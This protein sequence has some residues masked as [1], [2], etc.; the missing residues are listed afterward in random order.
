[1]SEEVSANEV[2]AVQAEN[3][4][5]NLNTPTR[6]E[7]ALTA[8]APDN[9]DDPTTTTVTETSPNDPP[10]VTDTLSACNVVHLDIP[11]T[12]VEA[13]SESETSY[14]QE[15][16]RLRSLLVAKEAENVNLEQKLADQEQQSRAQIEQ[17]HQNFT[18]KLE[19][20]LRK[21][22]ESQKDKTSSMV[23]KYA[24]AEKRC[25]DL[26]QKINLLQSKLAAAANEKQRLEERMSKSK[27]ETDKLNADYDQRV[28]DIMQ[29]K[30][31]NDKL[32]EQLV[33]NE[34]KE[35]AG[36]IK[37]KNEAEQH[38]VTK[39]LLE[40]T[41]AK[42]SELSAARAVEPKSETADLTD[43]N[44]EAIRVSV[45]VNTETDSSPSGV[46]EERASL[47]TGLSP[48]SSAVTLVG[49]KTAEKDRTVRE[50]Y[51][52]KSQL[53]DMFEERTSLRDKLQCMEQERKS[54]EVSF[55]RYKETLQSQ[56]QMNKEL[57]NE[58]LQLRDLQETLTK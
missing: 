50:L 12:E 56:K 15:V 11:D 46:A 44:V 9:F 13:E 19:Q 38:N 52:L 16:T 57:L 37:Y 40:Q 36:F 48:S 42:V 47:N 58:I 25:I 53:K 55:N 35:N 29:L 31:D 45:V 28:R 6:N 24:D 20:T 7:N 23:M 30:R 27:I 2:S 5:P 22:Q 43:V 21:F 17:L 8:T 1:M 4:D 41:A 10:M 39:R 54:Q 32:K 33:L 51:A 18:L 34:A 3:I 49:P 14:E 26:N